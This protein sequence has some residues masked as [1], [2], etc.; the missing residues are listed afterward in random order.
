MIAAQHPNAIQKQRGSIERFRKF[1][2]AISALR[3]ITIEGRGPAS[4]AP[5]FNLSRKVPILPVIRGLS[6]I[7]VIR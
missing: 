1:P 4:L 6:G 7:S 3:Q 2:T 5:D